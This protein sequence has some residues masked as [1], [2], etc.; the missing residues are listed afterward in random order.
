MISKD[1][2]LHL[3]EVQNDE[4][5]QNYAL[6]RKPVDKFPENTGF[7]NVFRATQDLGTP[8]IFFLSFTEWCYHLPTCNDTTWPTIAT[9][10]CNGTRQSPIDIVTANVQGNANLTA[11]NFTGYNDN[12]T[13]V[14]IENTGDT[15]KVSLSDGKMTVEGG[16]LP[17]QYTSIQFHLHWGNGSTM[18]G[19]EHTVDGKRYAMELHIV[20]FKSKHNGNLTALLEDSTGLAA[21]GF[22]I[23]A[24]NETGMPE[25]WKTLTSYLINITN[26]GDQVSITDHVSMDDLLV[27]VDRTKYYR[28]LGSLTTPNCNEAVVWTVFKDPIK[29]SHD[30][31]DLFS[32][33]V[34]VNTSSNSPL[35]TNVYRSIQPINGRTVTSQLAVTPAPPTTIAPTQGGG[36]SGGGTSSAAK[37]FQ[38][39]SMVA[40]LLYPIFYWL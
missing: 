12:T 27:G 14:K 40:L 37:P 2:L 25:S 23:E 21:L 32:T 7:S 38:A 31:I 26:K 3:S 11:F 24:T 36:G 15:V 5:F 33:T 39:L 13:M 16:D 17:G 34:Y 30:L 20:N 6:L 18:G 4:T 35:M 28:Y 10:F 1:T 29:V 19:S 9:E 22:F 8:Q